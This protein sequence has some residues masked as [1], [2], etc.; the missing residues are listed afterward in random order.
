MFSPA[1]GQTQLA[2]RLEISTPLMTSRMSA[3]VDFPEGRSEAVG[4]LHVDFSGENAE[5]Y[6]AALKSPICASKAH[7]KVGRPVQRST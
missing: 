5:T 2:G 6:A 7:L 4:K 3:A 1:A